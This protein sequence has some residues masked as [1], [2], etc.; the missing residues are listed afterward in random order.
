MH[1]KIGK[2]VPLTDEDRRSYQALIFSGSTVAKTGCWLWSKTLTSAGYGR[3]NLN[4][5][6]WFVHRLAYALYK[7]DP[8]GLIV[9]HTC[10]TPACVNPDHLL[11]GTQADNVRDRVLRGRSGGGV[12]GRSGRVKLPVDLKV[13]RMLTDLGYPVRRIAN[14]FKVS[15][16]VIYNR[17]RSIKSKGTV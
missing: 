17:L 6:N 4:N 9:R 15:V 5:G 3:I 2:S 11:L 12:K 16:D 7:G 13:L 8:V 1:S 10:D 14:M